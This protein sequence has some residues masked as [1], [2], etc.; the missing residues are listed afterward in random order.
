MFIFVSVYVLCIYIYVICIIPTAPH[1]GPAPTWKLHGVLHGAAPD[2]WSSSP[3]ES[4][5]HRWSKGGETIG[6]TNRYDDYGTL[7]F[8]E[9]KVIP[10]VIGSHHMYRYGGFLK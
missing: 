4:C 9:S 8:P 2:A 7:W 5:S 1:P 6:I 3:G 10:M